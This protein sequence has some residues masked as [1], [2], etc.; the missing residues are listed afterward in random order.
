MGRSQELAPLPVGQQE[1]DAFGRRQIRVLM[2]RGAALRPVSAPDNY[3]PL[4]RVALKCLHYQQPQ[5][6][7]EEFGSVV[8]ALLT[9]PLYIVAAFALAEVI[10]FF[11]AFAI[12]GL[13]LVL[14]VDFFTRSWPQRLWFRAGGW[15]QLP[16]MRRIEEE[17]QRVKGES[18]E[19]R[20]LRRLH[21]RGR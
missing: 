20:S 5:S 6:F 11:A 14:L 7:L 8:F 9:L 10:N 3:G 12:V 13:P 17:K 16:E 19:R 21:L 18:R 2:K 1:A 4:K 15:R